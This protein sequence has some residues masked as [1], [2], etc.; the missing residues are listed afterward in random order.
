MSYVRLS[1]QQL[2][3]PPSDFYF[4][5]CHFATPLIIL[6]YSILN[7]SPSSVLFVFPWDSGGRGLLCHLPFIYVFPQAIVN[8]KV[9]KDRSFVVPRFHDSQSVNAGKGCSFSLKFPMFKYLLKNSSA[10]GACVLFLLYMFSLR[11]LSITRLIK[12]V[13]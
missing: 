11:L 5:L 4:V 2:V 13:P 10:L 1:C 7:F 9:D 3:L 6:L 12:T 8:N